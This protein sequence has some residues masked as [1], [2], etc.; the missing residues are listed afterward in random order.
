MPR[1][2]SRGFTLIEL[3][4]V[5]AIIAV[6]L[7][8]LL[9]AVQAAR[10]AARRMQCTNN[11]KQLGLALANYEGVVGGLPPSVIVAKNG[12]G[13]WSNG[14]SINGRLLPFMEQGSVFNSINFTLNYSSP[15]N[16]TIGQLT[17][18]SLLCPSEI[19][20]EPKTSATSKYGVANY[21]WNVGDWYVF[22]GLDSAVKGR[23][24]F[25][26]NRSRTLAE[27]VDG[28]S[29]TVM[30][31]EIKTYQSVLTKCTLSTV[32]EPGKI[33]APTASP[34]AAVPEYKSGACS[35][36]ASGHA[37]W[38]DG[39][40]LETGFTTAW[41]P[42]KAILGGTTMVDV[43]IVSVG[44]KSGGPTYAA[45]T[46]RSYHPGGVNSLFGDGSVRF[47]KSSI[48]GNTWRGL[49]TASGGEVIG[50]DSY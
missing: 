47:V 27:F 29:N 40:A 17:L 42:N 21:N 41:P 7:A 44:E 38:V 39:A 35:L 15:D 36:N 50:A 18:A 19:H 5:I 31:S 10:E 20:P 30:T 12:A 48:N 8:L 28:L 22:G 23:G 43:D 1:S 14:W 3:L 49:G 33:P 9:P 26:A 4:V 45:I 34:Y 24:A 46:S 2:E 16:T 32:L 13:F 6:L 25:G 37:E 11:L